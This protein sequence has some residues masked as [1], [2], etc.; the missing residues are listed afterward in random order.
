MTGIHP[1]AVVEDGVTV[2]DGTAVWRHAHLRAGVTIGR[3]CTV[4]GSAYIDAYV[5]IGD[6]VKIQDHA[7][8]YAP[9]LVEDAVFIGPA[10][11]LTNDR[12]PR[13][14]NPDLTPKRD[15]DW[16]AVGVVLRE[17]C[18]IGAHAV[19]VAPVTV[20]RWAMV[21]AGA[22]VVA[23]VPNHALVAGVPAR[24]IGWVG[25]AGSRLSARDADGAGGGR[26]QCPTTGEV[27][28]PNGQ[29]LTLERPA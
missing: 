27:Y 17:G 22:V 14:V 12:L 5:V 29:G 21:A 2:G 18:S 1:E 26:W 7:L 9:A 24:R 16:E 19:C 20:G 11:V 28:V 23:D 13:A 3:R 6:D 15:A 25:R 10:A 4:G 8:V